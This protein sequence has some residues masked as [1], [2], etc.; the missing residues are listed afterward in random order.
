MGEQVR[1]DGGHRKQ[2]AL[3]TALEGRVEWVAI[4]PEVELGLGVPRQTIQIE[5]QGRLLRLVT[6]ESRLDLTVQM[7]TWARGRISS[8]VAQGISG[9]VFKA[10]SPSCG[11]NSVAVANVEEKVSGLFAA[12]LISRVPNLP[13]AEDEDLKTDA[14]C[15]LFHQRVHS[16]HQLLLTKVVG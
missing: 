4:C 15:E 6:S 11:I 12:A 5:A 13:V 1:Y 8:L 9:Y 14:S 16:Y 10:R 3:L 2:S 7:E